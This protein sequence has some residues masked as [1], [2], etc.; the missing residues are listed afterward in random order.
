MFGIHDLKRRGAT[1]TKGTKADKKDA[2]GHKSDAM[3]E[4]YDH[5]VPVV[6]ATGD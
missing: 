6:P 4:V 5:S 3:L 1:D 2:T